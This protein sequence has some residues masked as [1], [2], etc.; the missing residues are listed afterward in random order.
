MVNHKKIR[1]IYAEEQKK[2]KKRASHLRIVLPPPTLVNER[3]SMDFVTDNFINGRR[4][5]T[6]TVIDNLSRECPLLE[7]G[8]SLT[9]KKVADALE[10]LARVRGYPSTITVDNGPEFISKALDLWAYQ[11]GVSLD[12]IRPGKPT[13][14][15]FIESFNGKLRDECL[16]VNLFVSL[17]DVKTKL[18]VWRKDYNEVRPHSSIGNLTPAEFVKGSQKTETAK[19]RVF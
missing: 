17:A 1:R 2:R 6:L 8:F 10:N 4:F 9:G 13:E 14:N 18:E 12:F 5:R 7:P 3:W 19:V 15:G 11:N 16:N